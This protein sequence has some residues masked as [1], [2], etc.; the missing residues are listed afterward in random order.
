MQVDFFPIL[1]DHDGSD[2]DG[3]QHRKRCRHAD[4]NAE[5]EQGNRDQGFAEAEGGAD[6]RGKKYDQQNAEGRRV[7]YLVRNRVA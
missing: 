1:H 4:G 7:H 5:G 3:D 6:Y 2:G